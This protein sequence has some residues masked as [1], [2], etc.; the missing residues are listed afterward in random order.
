MTVGFTAGC[1]VTDDFWDW[2][3]GDCSTKKETKWGCLLSIPNLSPCFRIFLGRRR[4]FGMEYHT[5]EHSEMNS[6]L[7]GV[8]LDKRTLRLLILMNSIESAFIVG[9]S[10][11]NTNKIASVLKGIS[12]FSV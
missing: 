10:W 6:S 8:P 11:V 5:R 3:K 4:S 9:C 2:I 7:T 1:A 12:G